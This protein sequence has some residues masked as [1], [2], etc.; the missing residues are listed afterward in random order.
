M[1]S[2]VY[3]VHV[4]YIYRQQQ[5]FEEVLKELLFMGGGEWVLSP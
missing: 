1:Q 5:A 3:S 2:S 4:V